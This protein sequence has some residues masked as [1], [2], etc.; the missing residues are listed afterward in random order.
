MAVL[1]LAQIITTRSPKTSFIL[2]SSRLLQDTEVHIKTLD[3]YATA[4]LNYPLTPRILP[5]LTLNG[6]LASI[7]QLT[8]LKCLTLTMI[9]FIPGVAVLWKANH[10]MNFL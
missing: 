3:L 4:V 9:L 5:V 7:F 1:I 2:Y 6:A 10:L 8:V